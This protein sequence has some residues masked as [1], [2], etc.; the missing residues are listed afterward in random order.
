M[1]VF[2][3]RRIPTTHALCGI[4]SLC[5]YG[6]YARHDDVITVVFQTVVDG[7]AGRRASRPAGGRTRE[8]Y[9]YNTRK[10]RANSIKYTGPRASCPGRLLQIAPVPA[11]KVAT[12]ISR[13]PYDARVYSIILFTLDVAVA[14]LRSTPEAP[15]FLALYALRNVR[16]A[17]GR[18]MIHEKY[19][20]SPS[21]RGLTD[22]RPV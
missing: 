18:V 10:Q 9:L 16:T 3:P 11:Y 5:T 22:P 13:H 21:F 17:T 20:A 2:L 19:T 15:F 8:T 7:R 14:S 4:L 1:R 6:A 12:Y